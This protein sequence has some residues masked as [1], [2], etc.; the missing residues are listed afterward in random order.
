MSEGR[1]KDEVLRKVGNLMIEAGKELA[2]TGFEEMEEFADTLRIKG[3]RAFY[4]A[5]TF[6]QLDQSE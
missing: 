2:G 1:R 4:L 5:S 6:T 3:I